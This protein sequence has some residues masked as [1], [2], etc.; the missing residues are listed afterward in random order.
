MASPSYWRGVIAGLNKKIDE[1]NK[2]IENYDSVYLQSKNI[3]KMISDIIPEIKSIGKQLEDII[4]NGEAIDKGSLASYA[5]SLEG[6][7]NSF[8]MLSDEAFRLKS[9]CIVDRNGLIQKRNQAN[10]CLAAAIAAMEAELE[11]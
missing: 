1:K 7:R 9:E 10:A 8:Q 4:I 11:E 2:E 3:V 6:I 5:S